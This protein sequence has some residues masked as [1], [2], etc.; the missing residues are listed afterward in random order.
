MK[1]DWN[2]VIAVL[3]AMAILYGA[4]ALLTKQTVNKNTGEIKTSFSGFGGNA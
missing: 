1:I 3:I 2:T 4:Y